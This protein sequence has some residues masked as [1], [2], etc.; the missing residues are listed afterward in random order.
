MLRIL[1]AIALL[2]ACTTEHTPRAWEMTSRAAMP[3][4]V[5]T[6]DHIAA[7]TTGSPQLAWLPFTGTGTVMRQSTLQLRFKPRYEPR[8]FMIVTCAREVYLGAPGRTV[9]Y[10]YTPMAFLENMDACP[11]FAVSIGTKGQRET[12]VLDFV[13]GDRLPADVFCNG[14]KRQAI[15]SDLCQLRNGLAMAIW[16]DELT[17]VEPAEGCGMPTPDGLRYELVVP[18]G[19]CTYTFLGK[20]S[21][22]FFRLTTRGYDAIL[23]ATTNE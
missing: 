4:E 7:A 16:F 3:F 17:D 2:F 15:G 20:R 13:T 23:E 19:H 6:I 22:E 21:G 5:R 18:R 10:R 9:E 14:V 1:P 12:A 11:L 8:D